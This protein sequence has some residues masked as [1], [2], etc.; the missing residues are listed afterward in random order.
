MVRSHLAQQI[1]SSLLQKQVKKMPEGRIFSCFPILL[2]VYWFS[3]A[4]LFGSLLFVFLFLF[5]FSA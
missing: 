2:F 4:R 3:A 5:F 1:D